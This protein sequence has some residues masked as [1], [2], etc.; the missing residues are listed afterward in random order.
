MHN[1]RIG[2]TLI[3]FG[4]FPGE[5]FKLF[6]ISILEIHEPVEYSTWIVYFSIQ[7]G[8]WSFGITEV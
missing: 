4:H 2:N 5:P 1:K 6:A 8:R 3:E 7:V